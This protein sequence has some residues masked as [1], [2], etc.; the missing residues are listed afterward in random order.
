MPRARIARWDKKLP[1]PIADREY[2]DHLSSEEIIFYGHH[3][4]R[5]DI[6]TYGRFIVS[7]TS[8]LEVEVGDNSAIRHR[9]ARDTL[10]GVRYTLETEQTTAIPN[11]Y[12]YDQNPVDYAFNDWSRNPANLPVLG[13][14]DPSF[15]EAM[16]DCLYKVLNI[17]KALLGVVFLPK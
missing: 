1:K 4:L 17:S 7:G 6:A 13:Y 11:E 5:L 9:F 15:L 16:D 8:V 14:Y 2:Y 10:F 12:D 3:S